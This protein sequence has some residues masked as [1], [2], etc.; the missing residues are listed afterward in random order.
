MRQRVLCFGGRDY[1]DATVI[2]RALSQLAA[3]QSFTQFAVIQG[4]ARGA[5]ALCKAWGLKHGHP[6]LNL[7][8]PWDFYGKKAGSLRNSWMLELCA[9]TYAVGFP[10]GP[11]SADMA[12]QLRAAGVTI[13]FPVGGT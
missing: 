7:D 9:P 2:D 11:G 4:G 12:R 8:A 3:A 10:G 1:R 5:D 6:V 13:W